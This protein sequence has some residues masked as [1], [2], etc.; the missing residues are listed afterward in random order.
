MCENSYKCYSK[1]K[2]LWSH[3]CRLNGL[4]VTFE[5]G[6]KDFKLNKLYEVNNEENLQEENNGG[7]ELFKRE[8]SKGKRLRR[9]DNSD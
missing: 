6:C 1:V 2:P 9:K 4:T 3:K 8:S 5:E 7:K